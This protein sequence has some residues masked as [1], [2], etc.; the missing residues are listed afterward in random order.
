MNSDNIVITILIIS[1]A[2]LVF[3][4][5]FCRLNILSHSLKLKKNI[6]RAFNIISSKNL[7]D[8]Q[9]RKEILYFSKKNISILFN[10]TTSL[11]FLLF[12]FA[13][14]YFFISYLCFHNFTE[15]KELL[16]KIN[17]QITIFIVAVIYVYIRKNFLRKRYAKS[18]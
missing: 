2:I 8:E 13:F 10:L 6:K 5:L 7:N 9:K 15:T 14:F 12:A 18:S 4:E 11:I 17:T 1:P 3:V 16:L